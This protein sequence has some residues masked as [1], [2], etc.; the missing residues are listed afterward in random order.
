MTFNS[1]LCFSLLLNVLN[2]PLLLPSYA[3]SIHL[4]L[5]ELEV[6]QV[7]PQ[8]HLIM[9]TKELCLQSQQ[10]LDL[11]LIWTCGQSS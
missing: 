1:L 8:A 9:R 3:E 2:A 10:V 5:L 4:L 7:P 6:P 11:T